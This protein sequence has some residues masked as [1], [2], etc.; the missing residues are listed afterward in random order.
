LQTIGLSNWPI[1]VATRPDFTGTSRFLA[2][3]SRP[4]SRQDPRQDAHVQ[5]FWS[6]EFYGRQKNL[7]LQVRI[8]KYYA[9]RSANF[10]EVAQ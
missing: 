2:Y 6:N 1:N 4:A 7:V 3:L 10:L 8:T 5:I 9:A